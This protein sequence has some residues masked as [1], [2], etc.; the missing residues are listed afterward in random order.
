MSEHKF[1]KNACTVCGVKYG[2]PGPTDCRVQV[3]DGRFAEGPTCNDCHAAPCDCGQHIWTFDHESGYS[4]AP[5]TRSSADANRDSYVSIN[6]PVGHV[7]R[8]NEPAHDFG[9]KSGAHGLGGPTSRVNPYRIGGLQPI[10]QLFNSSQ[11]AIAKSIIDG[12]FAEVG[13]CNDCHASPCDCDEPIWCYDLKYAS[14]PAPSPR[15]DRPTVVGWQSAVTSNTNWSAGPVRRVTEPAHDFGGGPYWPDEF[16]KNVR[17]D[18]AKALAEMNAKWARDKKLAPDKAATVTPALPA[19]NF[20]SLFKSW[21]AEV[22]GAEPAVNREEWVEPP[23]R[24]IM[25]ARP[26]FQEYFAHGM[27]PVPVELAHDIGKSHPLMSGEYSERGEWAVFLL[28]KEAELA[29]LL[30]ET[31]PA[32][33]AVV[34]RVSE[35]NPAKRE[36][37][38][39]TAVQRDEAGARTRACEL[40][41]RVVA[42]AKERAR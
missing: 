33:L 29:G 22:D 39:K 3:I 30:A 21:Q 41:A 19:D 14:G 40:A 34:D 27:A 11:A 6:M 35:G 36:A 25:A 15:D 10:D 42:R 7:R 13:P 1:W 23:I 17:A 5:C 8:A 38:I 16:G 18:V 37:A 32:L 26:E 2:G 20:L 9:A 24:Q 12:Q 31:D 4:G 28:F